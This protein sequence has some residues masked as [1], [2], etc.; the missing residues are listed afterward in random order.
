MTMSTGPK[1]SSRAM[2]MSLF[3]SA[4]SV[5]CTNQPLSNCSGRPPP[6]TTRAPSAL[7]FSM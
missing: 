1:I 2:V 5:G 3:T 6:A 4:K 7:P